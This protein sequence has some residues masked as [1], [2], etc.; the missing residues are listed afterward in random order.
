MKQEYDC[1]REI[2][3]MRFY[4]RILNVE[5]PGSILLWKKFLFLWAN[6]LGMAPEMLNM[7]SEKLCKR[8]WKKQKRSERKSR[9]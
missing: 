2:R 5:E 7:Y 1:K 3:H 6:R 4:R 8:E 9:V